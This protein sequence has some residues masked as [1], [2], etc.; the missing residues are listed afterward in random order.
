MKI[1]VVIRTGPL[2]EGASPAPYSHLRDM[3]LRIEAAGF[4]SI[5]LYDHLLYRWPDRPTTDGIWECWTVLTALAATTQRVELGTMVLCTAFRNPA[6]LAKMAATLDEVSSGRLILG[7]GAGWHQPEFDAFGFPFD[8]RVARFEE[9]V[10]VIK[11][12]LRDGHVDFEGRYV[13]APNCESIP[14]GPRPSGPPLLLAGRGPRML[15]VVARAADA[16]NTAW[17]PD[18]DSVRSA[19]ERLHEAC[20]TV[21]RD[22]A[23]LEIT[24]ALAVAYPDL[25]GR[26][27]TRTFVSG[28]ADQIADVLAGYADLGVGHMIIELA[29]FSPAGVERLTEAFQRYR[30]SASA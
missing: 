29:P 1:G 9:A 28:G 2:G 23:T 18:L 30:A 13:S 25:Q 4:D 3:A 26:S 11:P 15:E 27:Y 6:L 5:W 14:R 7:L 10:A 8:H 21:G 17:H 12:L 16:W 20:E 22:P 24:A 19:I